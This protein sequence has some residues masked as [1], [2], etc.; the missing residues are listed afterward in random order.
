MSG[1]INRFKSYYTEFL[2]EHSKTGTKIFLFAGFAFSILAILYVIYSG[3][4][5]FFWYVP[6]CLTIFTIIGPFM[7][8]RERKKTF[9]NILFWIKAQFL[10]F[11]QL[12]SGKVKF[13]E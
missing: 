8:E 7:F 6:I 11:W 4:E 12:L 10:M 1:N 13:I 9:S 5:R 2:K 3:K